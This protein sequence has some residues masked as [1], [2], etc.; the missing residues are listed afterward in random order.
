MSREQWVAAHPYLAPLADLSNQIERSLAAI[1][2][3]AAA[4][5]DWDAYRADYLAGVPLL[6]SINAP[7]D[8][9]PGTR[10]AIALVD[11]L[12][13]VVSQERL[14]SELRALS[15]YLQRTP[16]PAGAIVELL[17]G[18]VPA[19]APFPGVLRYIA[20][21]ATARYLRPVTRAFDGVRDDQQ[22]HRGYCPCCGSLPAMA[23][24]VGVD[25]GR[26]RLL[27]CG[28]CGMRWQFKRTACPFCDGESQSIATVKIDSEPSLRIDHCSACSGYLKTYVGEGDEPLML[29]DWSS[30]HLD[31]IAHERGL[32]RQAAS[33]YE[34]E[35]ASLPQ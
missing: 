29:A 33:L 35:P 1:D 19:G 20:W 8:L 25:H 32:K 28:C 16:H 21:T 15:G 12:A 17:S 3:P 10:I 26:K 2:V 22:W 13:P 5:P 14:A 4:V 31:L 24:L 9:E 6:E 34:L 23:Q 11:R 18:D 30:L 27:S 7:V